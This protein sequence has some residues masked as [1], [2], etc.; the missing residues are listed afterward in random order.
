LKLKPAILSILGRDDLKG[1]LDDLEMDGVDRRSVD[2]MQAALR[3]ARRATPEVLLGHLRKGDIQN[4]CE[5][6]GVPAKGKKDELIRRLLSDGDGK[7]TNRATKRS[8]RMANDVKPDNGPSPK[9]KKKAEKLTLAK[10]ESLLLRACDI[11]RGNMD[12]SEYKEYV[13]GMLFLKRMSDQFEKD[14]A[15]L[16][17]SYGPSHKKCPI[18]VDG[19]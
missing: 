13:F 16:Q 4:V 19:R 8:N 12:A 6:L 11:L 18:G 9:P 3:R 2:A 5:L 10:L 1:I 15:A 7:P 14:R 17:A